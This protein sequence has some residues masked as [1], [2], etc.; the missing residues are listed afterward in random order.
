[1]TA[2]NRLLAEGKKVYWLKQAPEDGAGEVGD[3]YIPAAAVTPEA[4][5]RL[6]REL[7]VPVTP[8]AAAPQGPAFRVKP[9]RVGL[10]KPW[11]ANMDEGWTR[12]LLERYGFAFQNLDNERAEGRL[13][14]RQGGHHPAALDAGEPDREGG[15]RLG[16]GPPV[17]GAAAARLCRRD[18][19]GRRREAR[20]MGGGRRCP[21]SPRR[22]GGVRHRPLRAA[23]EERPRRPLRRAVQRSRLHVPHPHGHG[24]PPELRHERRGSGLFRR[25]SRLP[26]QPSR[27]PFRA[28]RRGHL[29]G[30]GRGHPGQRLPEGRREA[31]EARPPWWSTRSARA[32]SS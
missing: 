14:P 24:A 8:L 13:L 27:R 31:G 6:S 23:G 15:A 28:P 25:L 19:R 30:G 21:G 10:Y 32:G 26:D 20:E 4:M 29:S 3:L 7:H 9:V 18:R 12:F 1:M 2:Q 11:I 16:R 22:L 17:L 5:S